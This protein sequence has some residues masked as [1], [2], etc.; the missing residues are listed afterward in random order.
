MV[1]AGVFDL[2]RSHPSTFLD[3]TRVGDEAWGS[4]LESGGE[5]SD[6][7]GVSSACSDGELAKGSNDGITE[8]VFVVAFENFNDDREESGD[9]EILL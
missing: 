4:G 3:K 5:G 9:S 2:S 8:R 1:G 6:V 7:E